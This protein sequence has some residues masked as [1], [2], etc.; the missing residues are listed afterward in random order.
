VRLDAHAAARV[1][2]TENFV[3]CEPHGEL[4][5]GEVVDVATPTQGLGDWG[6]QV[7]A[8][9]LHHG[10]VRFPDLVGV[11][12]DWMVQCQLAIG[13][14]V[15]DACHLVFGDEAFLAGEV[16][17]EAHAGGDSMAVEH[18]GEQFVARAP[19]VAVGMGAALMGFPQVAVLGADV[20]LHGLAHN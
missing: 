20:A 12:H 9:L 4:L 6:A 8:A 5:H 19:R 2:S 1:S 18:A 14:H 10:K 16:G 11:V 7:S 17:P 3:L 15:V 13:D